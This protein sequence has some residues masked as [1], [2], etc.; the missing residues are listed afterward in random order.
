M[1]EKENIAVGTSNLIK[2]WNIRPK[3]LIA[4][5]EMHDNNVWYIERINDEFFISGGEDNYLLVWKRY[6]NSFINCLK[7]ESNPISKIYPIGEK[8]DSKLLNI[9]NDIINKL[10]LN[11]I[12]GKVENEKHLN[13]ENLNI[14]E[15]NLKYTGTFKFINIENS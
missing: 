11:F 1:M 14:T 10:N 2:I 15:L 6:E 5:L 12:E 4:T 9:K 3:K 13:S 7:L 8:N